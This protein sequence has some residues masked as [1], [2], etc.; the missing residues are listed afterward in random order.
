MFLF[1]NIFTRQV[2]YWLLGD[3]CV[4]GSC[5]TSTGIKQHLK[6]ASSH[7]HKS[8]SGVFHLSYSM[9][10]KSYFADYALAVKI[11]LSLHI[12]SPLGATK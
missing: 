2:Y 8:T 11:E 1:G 10:T 5:S 3:W 12:K 7:W 4:N 6:S 9:P